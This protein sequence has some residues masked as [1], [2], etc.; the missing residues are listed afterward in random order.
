MAESQG[1]GPEVRVDTVGLL[2]C[3]GSICRQMAH[4]ES[5]PAAQAVSVADRCRGYFKVLH[6]PWL[7]FF[8]LLNVRTPQNSHPLCTLSL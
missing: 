1:W 5:V 3:Q 6:L 2:T 4:S 7:L 8:H